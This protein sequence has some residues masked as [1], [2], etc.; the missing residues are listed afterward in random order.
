M[1]DVDPFALSPL[2]WGGLALLLLVGG[3]ALRQRR[4]VHTPA[5]R[6]APSAGAAVDARTDDMP[7]DVANRRSPAL[8]IIAWN[9][10]AA[11][12]NLEPFQF[13]GR[14]A[15]VLLLAG[16]EG[17]GEEHEA[18]LAAALARG[19][20][21][22]RQARALAAVSFGGQVAAGD[23]RVAIIMMGGDEHGRFIGGFTCRTDNAGDD[24]RYVWSRDRWATLSLERG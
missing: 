20:T 17:P 6:P 13:D 10:D 22:A 21:L 4:A 24:P 23:V 5:M 19:D 18:W 16:P 3:L 7:P 2:I 12:Y 8:G 1:A 14:Q 11:W 15:Q 9:G